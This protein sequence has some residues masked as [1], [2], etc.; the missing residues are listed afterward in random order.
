MIAKMPE[1]VVSGIFLFECSAKKGS[2]FIARVWALG[3]DEYAE[4]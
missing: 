4:P 2:A 1:T 3:D